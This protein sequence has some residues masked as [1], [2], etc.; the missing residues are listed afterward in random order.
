[1]INELINGPKSEGAAAVA[2]SALLGIS[3]IVISSPASLRRICRCLLIGKLL[4]FSA[5]D[6]AVSEGNYLRLKFR[7]LS[8]KAKILLLQ[9]LISEARLRNVLLD[10]IL[11]PFGLRLWMPNAEVSEPGGPARPHRK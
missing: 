4:Y 1:M 10:H 5:C 3:L 7:N 2:C 9:C 11:R 8:L 6:I